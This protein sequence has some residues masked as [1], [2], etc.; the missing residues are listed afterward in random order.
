MLTNYSASIIQSA[1]DNNNI[2]TS[3][4]PKF[5]KVFAKENDNWEVSELAKQNGARRG[6]ETNP[7]LAWL[8][9]EP[10]SLQEQRCT[11][12]RE[13]AGEGGAKRQGGPEGGG[14]KVSER[15][16]ATATST[17]TSTSTAT[18]TA[19][20]TTKLTCRSGRD[21]EEELR[22]VKGM[23]ASCDYL[24]GEFEKAK[25]NFKRGLKNCGDSSLR[26]IF[27]NNLKVAGGEGDFTD[28]H[29]SESV[30]MLPEQGER[31][32]LLAEVCKAPN[33]LLTRS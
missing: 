22:G 8:Q 13:P 4:N 21:I 33:P 17:S 27:Q 9:P 32:S 16:T 12:V 28:P 10:R 5:E 18:A 23:V 11:A 19:T 7:L 31:A 6:E 30:R 20:A 3:S 1:N 24:G 2:S 26:L 14:I 25:S 29:S 15:T